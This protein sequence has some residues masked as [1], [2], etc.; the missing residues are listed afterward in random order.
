MGDGAT[1]LWWGEAPERPYDW[2]GAPGGLLPNIV[3][4][5]KDAPS[6]GQPLDHGSARA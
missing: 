5:P 2:A 3:S 1:Y 6:R 4:T